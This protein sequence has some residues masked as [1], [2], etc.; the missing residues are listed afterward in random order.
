MLRGLFVTGTDTNVGKTVV[1]AAL[2]IRYRPLANLRYWKPIQTGIEHDDDTAE[3][4]RLAG[5]PEIALRLEG[6]RLARPVSPHL[7]AQWSGVT[8]DLRALT[9]WTASADE[10]TRWIVEGAG[11]VRVPLNDRE[12]VADLIELLD[13][14]A[15]VVA[16]PTLGTINHSLL[17]I[18]S[19]RARGLRVAGVILAG[20][21]NRDNRDAIERYGDVAV[22]GEMPRFDPL[23]PQTLAHW[24]STELDPENRLAE[25]L[26]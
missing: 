20:E 24:V 13:L 15:L 21:K 2:M 3:V 4:Q 8:I 11:G 26:L 18:E 23:S 19:L 22:L 7:A 1:S 5:C 12:E 25:H 14:P 9:A 16:R 17:T 10:N 6:V